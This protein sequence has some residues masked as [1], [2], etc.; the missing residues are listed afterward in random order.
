MSLPNTTDAWV[1]TGTGD[2]KGLGNL[3]L[4]KDRPIGDL[5]EYGV[6]VQIQAVSLNY[7]DLLIPKVWC[8]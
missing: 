7:R 1:V 8:F 3:E 6:L 4:Q 5:G 2:N